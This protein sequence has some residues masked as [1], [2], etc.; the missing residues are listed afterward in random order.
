[1]KDLRKS[2]FFKKFVIPRKLSKAK[3]ARFLIELRKREAV[4]AQRR[5]KQIGRKLNKSRESVIES[6]QTMPY[7][8][9]QGLQKFF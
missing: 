4:I 2:N 9:L 3:K 5:L 8:H 1:M 6:Q 7:K